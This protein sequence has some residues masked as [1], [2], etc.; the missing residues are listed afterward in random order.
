MESQKFN[1]CWNEFDKA[2]TS[3]FKQLVEDQH[4][5]DVTIGCDGD[6]TIQVPT[7]IV[8]N[9]L[10]LCFILVFSLPVR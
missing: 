10:V 6:D 8:F 3:T 9:I 2:A 5:T 4:F 1:L 7:S